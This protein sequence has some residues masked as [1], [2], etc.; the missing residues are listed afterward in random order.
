VRPWWAARPVAVL[1]VLLAALV[2]GARTATAD[3]PPPGA[4]VIRVQ[5]KPLPEGVRRV[6]LAPSAAP[7]GVP[8]Y[9]LHYLDGHTERVS[10]DEFARRLSA[11][12]AERGFLYRLLNITSPIGIGWVVLGLL[13]QV[14]FTGRML[15][16]WLASE[17]ERRSVVPVAFWWMSLAGASMLLVYF[18][19]RKD[20][21]GVLGQSAGWVVYTRNLWLIY[22]HPEDTA[23]KPA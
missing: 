13:G 6:E 5:V 11:E 2:A 9:V 21:I 15:V 18:L 12:A 19:W 22:R 4:E 17:R 23:P 7:D 10:P 14:L 8:R 16:Q 1:L 20:I 3:P